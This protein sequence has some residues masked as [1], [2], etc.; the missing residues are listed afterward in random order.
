MGSCENQQ[1][2]SIFG[3]TA[4]SYQTPL[5]CIGPIFTTCRVFSDF[6]MPSRRPRVIPATLSNLVP[7]IK[8]LSRCCV[9][10]RTFKS[11]YDTEPTFTTSNTNALGFDLETQTS[12]I[13]PECSCNPWFHARRRNLPGGVKWLL[14]RVPLRRCGQSRSL[15]HV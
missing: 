6:R 7:L 5:R 10:S 14:S 9:S 12:F 3:H 2:D 13:F 1:F 15:R 4:F 8:W 11:K